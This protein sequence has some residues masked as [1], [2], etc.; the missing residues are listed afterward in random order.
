MDFI[1]SES[2]DLSRERRFNNISDL[3]Y[4]QVGNKGKKVSQILSLLEEERTVTVKGDFP[5]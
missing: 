2:C 4:M 3:T 1:I 5:L